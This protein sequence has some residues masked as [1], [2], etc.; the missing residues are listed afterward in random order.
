MLNV[1]ALNGRLTADPELRHTS[2]DIAVT[3]FS[4]AVDRSYSRSST[5]RQTDFIDIVCWRNT[6]EFASKYFHKGQLI[7]VEGSIQTRSY[8][9]RDGNKRRALEVVANNVH[10]AEPK[11]AAE[12]PAGS[13]EGNATDDPLPPP[14][15]AGDSRDFVEIDVTDDLPF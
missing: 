15:V 8:T 14:P 10:F 9:D 12:R 6:A 3:S 2:N 5:E 4:L 7:A 1:V 11:R 13:S